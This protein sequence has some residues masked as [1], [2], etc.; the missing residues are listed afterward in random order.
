MTKKKITPVNVKAVC[1]LTSC[2]DHI[3]TSFLWKH[4]TLSF[5]L[6]SS[7]SSTCP[8][9]WQEV[10]YSSFWH[11]S[12]TLWYFGRKFS[13]WAISFPSVLLCGGFLK[14]QREHWQA[15]R[16]GQMT[17][18]RTR[19]VKGQ[20]INRTLSPPGKNLSMFYFSCSAGTWRAS[21]N[22]TVIFAPSKH[23]HH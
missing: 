23:E 12:F 22:H 2:C 6:S 4:V 17:G 13:S 20:S 5:S 7:R 1:K 18:M 10:W 19:L 9:C 15:V 14:E 16:S 11:K 21:T 3:Q 8:G